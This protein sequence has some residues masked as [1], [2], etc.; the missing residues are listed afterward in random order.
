MTPAAAGAELRLATYAMGTRFELVIPG[1][2]SEQFR[3]AAEAAMEE[4]ETAHRLFTPFEPDS[5]LNHLHRVAADRPVAVD[6]DTFA[7]FVDALAVWRASE[8]AFDPTVAPVLE[9]WGFHPAHGPSRGRFTSWA[10]AI[11]LDPA[12]RTIGFGRKGLRLDFGGIAKGH[13]LDLA[14]RGL[15]EHGVSAAFLHGGTSSAVGL[16]APA[17]EAGW[18][19]SLGPEHQ[20][21]VVVLHD[22][23][24]AVSG[25]LGRSAE[26]GGRVFSHLIDPQAGRPLEGRGARRAAVV[27]C[28]ARLADAWSTALLVLGAVPPS[29]PDDWL[30]WLGH[31]AGGWAAAPGPWSPV[32]DP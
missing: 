23:A 12:T 17:G 14:A 2:E 28:S 19:V 7:L 24:V 30:A 21:P 10:G 13:A 8:G 27:G 26:L 1:D 6:A 22:S 5:W 20:A 3:P 4:I 16:G 11:L 18:R 25:T 29:F 15:R 9:A 31:E 32:P